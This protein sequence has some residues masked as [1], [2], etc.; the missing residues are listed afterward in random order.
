MYKSISFLNCSYY[1]ERAELIQDEKNLT[2]EE[3]T[4]LHVNTKRPMHSDP[5]TFYT[6]IRFI[7]F[8][9]YHFDECEEEIYHE[10]DDIGIIVVSYDLKI[11]HLVKIK[12]HVSQLSNLTIKLD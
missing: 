4:K 3:R 1:A 8:K 12:S 10:Q 2:K 11:R 7:D 6:V 5:D 9:K